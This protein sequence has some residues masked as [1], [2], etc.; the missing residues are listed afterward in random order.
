MIRDADGRFSIPRVDARA[1]HAW[2]SIAWVILWLFSLQLGPV[3]TLRLRAAPLSGDFID[4]SSVALWF[5]TLTV[6]GWLLRSVGRSVARPV[7]PA[8]GRVHHLFVVWWCVLA[9]S[10]VWSVNRARTFV[11]VVLL[12]GT[13]VAAHCAASLVGREGFLASLWISSQLGAVIAYR[14]VT[15]KWTGSIDEY[16]QWTGIY[17]NRNSLGPVAAMGMLTTVGLIGSVYRWS[18]RRRGTVAVRAVAITVGTVLF[19]IDLRLALGARSVTS[20][21]AAV[22]TVAMVVAVRALRRSG[23]GDRQALTFWG[24]V[25]VF[26]GGSAAG[27]V[28]LRSVAPHILKKASNFNGRSTIW[29]V[30]IDGIRVHP[31]RGWG[32]MA[33]WTNAGFMTRVAERVGQPIDRAHNG[34]LEVALGSGLIGTIAFIVLIGGAAGDALADATRVSLLSD[35]PLALIVY[36]AV[37]NTMESFTGANVLPW[38]LVLAAVTMAQGSYGRGVRPLRAARGVR[39]ESST[40]VER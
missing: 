5:V 3:Y 15:A 16:G 31:V 7:L 14:A 36:A 10:T 38:A 34:L 18:G 21:A 20:A 32:W 19:A 1:A 30:V 26:L 35:L 6:V 22:A 12:A 2:A 27:V 8:V 24:S 40:A 11:Q 39:A 4:D 25:L 33:A 29:R 37:M 9:L 23:G 28:A 17:F 13:A